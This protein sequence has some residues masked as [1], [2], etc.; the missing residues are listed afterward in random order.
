MD[1]IHGWKKMRFLL[2]MQSKFSTSIANFPSF[3]L[4]WLEKIFLENRNWLYVNKFIYSFCL[5]AI[6]RTVFHMLAFDSFELYCF[7]QYIDNINGEIGKKW[8]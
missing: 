5:K 2:G 3:P 6:G 1:Y 4:R 8:S 7:C